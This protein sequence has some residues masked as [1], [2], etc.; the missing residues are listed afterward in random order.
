MAHR[1]LAFLVLTILALG[2]TQGHAPETLKIGFFAPLT[3][4]AAADG[5]TFL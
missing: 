4:F 3:G 5:A 1:T 2:S